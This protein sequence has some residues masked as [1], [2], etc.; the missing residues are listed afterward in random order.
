MDGVAGRI[1]RWLLPKYVGFSAEFPPIERL[2]RSGQFND[3]RVL[4]GLTREDFL[5]E[6]RALQAVLTDSVIE[7]AVLALPRTYQAYEHDRL[8]PALRARR[9]RLVDYA[10]DY[11]RLVASYLM[12][13]GKPAN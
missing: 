7:A 3:H 13:Y 9:D 5:T 10:E 6:A 8:I 1:A 11:Y 4:G 12:V 2:A